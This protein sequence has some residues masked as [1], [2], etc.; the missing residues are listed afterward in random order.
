MVIVSLFYRWFN[1]P[2]PCAGR[3]RRSEA[4]GLPASRRWVAPVILLGTD[5]GDDRTQLEEIR[6]I[7]TDRTCTLVKRD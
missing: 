6:Q 2:R 1:N 3:G 5:F 4:I 7:G